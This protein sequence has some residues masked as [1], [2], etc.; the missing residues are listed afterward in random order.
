LNKSSAV[1]ETGDR[2]ATTDMDRK[3]GAAVTLS[4]EAQYICGVGQMESGTPTS[5]P[6]KWHGICHLDPSSRLATIDMG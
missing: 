1:P 5:V 2:L 4:G 6:I 3:V